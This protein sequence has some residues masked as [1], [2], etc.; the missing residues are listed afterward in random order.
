MENNNNS[1]IKLSSVL[2]IIS[3]CYLYMIACGIKNNFGIMLSSI[4]ENTG[5]AFASVSFVLAVG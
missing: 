2:L 5:L 1:R 4:V 3:A